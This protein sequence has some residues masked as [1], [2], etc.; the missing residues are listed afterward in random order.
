[1]AGQRACDSAV[2][3]GRMSKAT[4]FFDAADLLGKEMVNAAGDLYVDAGIAAAD[5]ICHVRLG[6]HSN[7]GNHNEAVALQKQADSGS[8]RH[9]NTLLNLKNKA[10]YTHQDLTS[11]ELKKMNRAAEQLVETGKRVVASRT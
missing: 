5:V 10:A 1:M 6:V 2:I 8:E 3:A 11:A 4:E 9:L 7:S